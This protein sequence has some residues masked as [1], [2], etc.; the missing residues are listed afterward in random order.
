MA[1]FA[2]TDTDRDRPLTQEDRWAAIDTFR[3]N[4][5]VPETIQIHFETAK[6]LY[7]YAWFAYRFHVV[8]EQQALATLEFAL[9]ERLTD[10]GAIQRDA[11]WVPGLKKLMGLAVNHGLIANE[12][13]QLRAHWAQQLAERRVRNDQIAEMM[14]LGLT[15]MVIN[16]SAVVPSQQDHDHD[17]IGAFV[18]SLP[19]LRNEYAHGSSML[20]ANVLY[21]FEV[22]NELVNQLYPPATGSLDLGSGK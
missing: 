18:D 21:T 9:R 22:V 6:N 7:L 1:Y 12:R 14:R 10:A 16:E 5:A 2:V 19:Y 13:I 15:E 8:A 11:D 20:H 17:W 4:P 3:S